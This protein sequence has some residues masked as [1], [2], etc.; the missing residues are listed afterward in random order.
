M[1]QL[2]LVCAKKDKDRPYAKWNTR[3]ALLS[4][5]L[6]TR[7]H[8]RNFL[9]PNAT[10]EAFADV[11]QGGS[12]PPSQAGSTWSDFGVM[13]NTRVNESQNLPLWLKSGWGPAWKPRERLLY[14]AVK[15][16]PGLC[17]TPQSHE[18]PVKERYRHWVERREEREMSCNPLGTKVKPSKSFDIGNGT[19]VPGIGFLCFSL[20]LVQYFL[21]PFWNG[22]ANSVLLYVGNT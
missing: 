20:V 13:K 5:W 18:T 14:K 22:H 1:L 19:T 16:K 21:T 8:L 10:K 12:Q 3:I 4:F 17:W 9:L 11:V 6:K 2:R 15:V 7:K